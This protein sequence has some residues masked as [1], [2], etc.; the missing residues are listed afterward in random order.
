MAVYDYDLII[1]GGG[2]GGFSASGIAVGLGKRV[3]IVEKNKLGGDCT[4]YGCVPSKALIRAA[5]VAH[6][7]RNA[8]QFGLSLNGGGRVCAKRVMKH[9]R[10]VVQA[11]YDGHRPEHL[12]AKGIDVIFGSPRFVNNEQIEVDG[13]TISARRFVIATGS[14]PLVPPIDGIDQVPYLTNETLFSVEELPDSLIVLGGGPI[15]IEMAAALN[16]L[17]VQVTV[18]EMME[19]ILVRDE[20]ELVDILVEQLRQEGLQL[21]TGHRAVQVKG[22]AQ[23]IQLTLENGSGQRKTIQANALLVAVGRRPNVAGL[24]LEKAGVAY[25]ARG[26]QTDQTLKT[27]APNIYAIGDVIGSYQFSHMAEYHATVATPNAL[28]PLPIKKKVSDQHVAWA[29]FTDPELA[30]AG[31]TEAEARERLGDGIRVYRYEY[32]HVDRARTDVA[33]VG[34]SKFITDRKGRL[35]GAHILGHRAADLIHEAQVVKVLGLPFHKI[36]K[37]IHIY[38]TYG[39]LIK[40]PADYSYVDKVKNNPLVKLVQALRGAGKN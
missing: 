40:R 9:V 3:A 23:Q 32:A 19:R 33:A 26:I 22:D 21:L 8:S 4:W 24:D 17:G 14:S 31:Y 11:V 6:L 28:L 36:S 12:Q 38:P 10:E 15:G 13:R 7:T 18:V 2:A 16:R 27:T 39:D 37:A 25:S 35:V 34:R 30:H 5:E 29:T 20:P 1:L